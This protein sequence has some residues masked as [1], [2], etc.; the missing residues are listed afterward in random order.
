MKRGRGNFDIARVMEYGLAAVMVLALGLVGLLIFYQVRTIKTA[1]I[2]TPVLIDRS[3]YY[4]GQTIIG[5]FFGE[6]YWTGAVQ[7]ERKVFCDGYS[8]YIPDDRTG[9]NVFN[10]V[11]RP[12][13]LE[14]VTS[15]IGLLPADVPIDKHCVVEFVNGYNYETPF[16]TRH[17]SITYYTQGF[18]VVA[19]P[20]EVSD[21]APA[22]SDGP[23]V[24]VSSTPVDQSTVVLVTPTPQQSIVVVAPPAAKSAPT[25]I[26]TPPAATPAPVQPGLIQRIL[27]DVRALL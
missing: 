26:P 14:G 7:V 20:V 12:H 15:R 8:A 1:D 13:K 4:A 25:P 3:T 17:L 5:T 24:V 27:Q 9:N 23:Q 10:G 16:G 2:R 6:I 21:A 19:K 11:S 18:T 22:A